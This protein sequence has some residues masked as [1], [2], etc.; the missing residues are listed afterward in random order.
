QK[1][2]KIKKSKEKNQNLSENSMNNTSQ[3]EY[4]N[5]D[6]FFKEEFDEL[7]QINVEEISMDMDMNDELSIERFFDIRTF[8]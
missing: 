1:Q 3:T 7:L 4:A 5:I 6:P 8:E 2:I